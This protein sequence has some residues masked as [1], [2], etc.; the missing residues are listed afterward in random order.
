MAFPSNR[1][2]SSA[3]LRRGDDLLLYTTRSCFHKPTNDRGRVIGHATVAS[4]VTVLDLSVAFGDRIFPVSCPL[5]PHVLAPYRT[6]VELAKYVPL[7]SAFPKPS[8]WSTS[9]RRVL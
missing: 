9:L 7:K 8:I 1:R 5:D 2:R 4:A 3:R 6:G